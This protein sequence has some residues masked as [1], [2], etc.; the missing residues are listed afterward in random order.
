VTVAT[1]LPN[2]EDSVATA[3]GIATA[4]ENYKGARI[5]RVRVLA[6]PR[7]LWRAVLVEADTDRAR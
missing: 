1:D 4:V 7:W 6:R 5:S 3:S 2:T